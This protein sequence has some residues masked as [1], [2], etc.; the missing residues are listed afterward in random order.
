MEQMS[1]LQ[2]RRDIPADDAARVDISDE[3]DERESAPGRG[4][5]HVDDP[6]SARRG[7][8]AFWYIGIINLQL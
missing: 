7:A 6:E 8:L 3:R 2:R 1:A 5:G 4:V